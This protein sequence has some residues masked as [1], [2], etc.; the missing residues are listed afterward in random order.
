MHFR[1]SGTLGRAWGLGLS[2]LVSLKCIF[3][4]KASSLDPM[5]DGIIHL[6]VLLAFAHSA[7]LPTHVLWPSEDIQSLIYNGL[8][9]PKPF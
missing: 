3:I 8:G 7:M 4:V 2:N 5:N 1:D 9:L 6:A